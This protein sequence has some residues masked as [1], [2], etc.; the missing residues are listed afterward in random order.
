M[1]AVFFLWMIFAPGVL[2][3]GCSSVQDRQANVTG[4]L[5]SLAD[6]A[7]GTLKETKGKVTDIVKTGKDVVEQGKVVVNDAMQVME[8]VN[9]RVEYVQTGIGKIQEGK[10]LIEEGL[11]G[12]GSTK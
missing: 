10:K 5:H 8:D 4:V 6:T 3:T 2:L 7:S 12:T 9:R 1:S 11:G